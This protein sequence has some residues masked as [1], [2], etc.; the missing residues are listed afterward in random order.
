[1]GVRTKWWETPRLGGKEESCHSSLGRK[2][3]NVAVFVAFELKRDFVLP[4][5]C[6]PAQ[7]SLGHDAMLGLPCVWVQGELGGERG[8]RTTFHKP[9]WLAD[10]PPVLLAVPSLLGSMHLNIYTTLCFH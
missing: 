3:R 9:Q 2:V 5:S 7:Q 1:M 6:P 4:W 10:S 8:C